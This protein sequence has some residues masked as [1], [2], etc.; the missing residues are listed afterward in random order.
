M[1]KEYIAHA[2]KRL[3]ENVGL[4]ADEV[5]AIVGKSGKTVNAWENGRGQPDAEILIKL[6]NIYKVNN[7]LAE[8]DNSNSIK[9]QTEF[10]VS[11][12]IIINKYRT[13]DEYGKKAIDNLLNV[14]YERC[15]A[16]V[17]EQ[18][19]PTIQIRHSYYKVS[20]GHGF[21]L[22]DGDA[23]EEI[24]VPDTYEARKADFALTI[25]G[26]SMQPV[27]FDGDIVLVRQQD[28]VDIGQIGIYV[29]NGAGYIKKN[30]GDRLISINEEYEDI[31]I[32]E[33]DDCRCVGKVIG[34]V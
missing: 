25:K 13:L 29:L 11:E 9:A 14:E 24:S 17:E 18:E 5:G 19:Q 10:S 7:I 1:S 33:Y 30:G 28:T 21:D 20:A 23:W 22:D 32:A 6:C 31:L 26:D 4:T 15:T 3:R 8:F 27:Y 12:H 2:L 16:P 34:R